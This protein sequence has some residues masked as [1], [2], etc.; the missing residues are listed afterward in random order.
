MAKISGC[1]VFSAETA[2]NCGKDELGLKITSWIQANPFAVLEDK[3]VVQSD[4]FISVLVF[5]SGPAG[6][7]NPLDR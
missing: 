1:V 7:V 4:N 6:G 5:F 3:H 2:K